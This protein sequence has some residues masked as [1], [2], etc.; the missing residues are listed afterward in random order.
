[1]AV[2][3]VSPILPAEASTDPGAKSACPKVGDDHPR[4][5]T[6]TGRGVSR[7]MKPPRILIFCAVVCVAFPA[8]GVGT[9]AGAQAPAGRTVALTF[10]DLPAV[11][12]RN[13]PQTWKSITKGIITALER[14][15]AP[16]TAFVIEGKLYDRERLDSGR[17]ALLRSW[18]GAGFEL[19]NHTYSHHSLY[20]TPLPEFESDVL[21]GEVVTKSLLAEHGR[22]IRWFRH[23]TL[24]TGPDLDTKRAFERFLGEHGY[25]IAP[26]TIDNQEWIFARAYDIA[27]DTGDVELRRRLE[28]DY[29]SYLDSIFG[30]YEQQSIALLG[31]ELPQILLLHANRINAALLPRVL[32]MIR[33][34]GYRFIS[35][36]QAIRDPAYA[37]EDGYAGTAGITWLHRWALTEGRRGS[38]FA[39]EPDIPQY[40][41]DLTGLRD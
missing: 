16:A 39:G 29:L 1:M 26:V 3:I 4:V 10:D 5:N 25:R 13:D 20:N 17:V 31:Y 19:G 34:R 8:I 2:R 15:S 27:L 32:R 38:F 6:G 12:T 37:R 36:E 41:H 9:A 30:Y 21:R 40:V 11:S 22:E 14:E 18:L 35:L 23:P 28:G 33:R 24:N 7:A